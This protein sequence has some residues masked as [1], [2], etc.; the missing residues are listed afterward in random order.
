[1]VGSY[2]PRVEGKDVRTVETFEV[3]GPMALAGIKGL[4]ATTEDRTIR[5]V[6]QRGMDRSRVNAEV[7][8]AASTFASIRHGAYRLLLTRWQDVL[9]EVAAA[10]IPNWL[11]ARPRELWKPLLILAT[12]ADLESGLGIRADLLALASE[13]VENQD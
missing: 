9:R 11:N 13:H 5:L 3:Y 1:K 4:N 6:L 10:S 7:N 8:P 2:V 12:V